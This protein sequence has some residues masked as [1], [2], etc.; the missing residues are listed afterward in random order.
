MFT[1]TYERRRLIMAG[2]VVV[3]ILTVTA[4][5]VFAKRSVEE[6]KV[7]MPLSSA[8]TTSASRSPTPPLAAVR[9]PRAFAIAAAQR[10]FDWD[11]ATSTNTDSLF[12][13][14]VA[15]ASPGGVESDGLVTDL[16]D[17]LPTDPTWRDLRLYRTRQWL[18]VTS[19]AVPSTWA[20]TARDGEAYGL[21]RGT[22]A[23]NIEGIR[24]RTGTWDRRPVSTRHK[25]AFTV[26]II[27]EPRYPSCYL[28]RLSRLDH[29]LP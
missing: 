28:L 15:I 2:A 25:V 7:R 11:T 29:P 24:H 16:T 9:E 3:V 27:C 14:L 8:A 26:F 10:I 6:G 20:A 4:A 1:R 23:Y 17:Y 18:Q 13:R 22:T 12:A 19:T 21:D 5:V